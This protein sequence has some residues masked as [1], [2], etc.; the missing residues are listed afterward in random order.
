[1]D[2]DKEV[3]VQVGRRGGPVDEM[4]MRLSTVRRIGGCASGPHLVSTEVAGCIHITSGV[5]HGYPQGYPQVLT[6]VLGLISFGGAA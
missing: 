1:E 4:S 2:V 3:S 5:I 6:V